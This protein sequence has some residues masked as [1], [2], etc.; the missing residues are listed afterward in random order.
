M[1]PGRRRTELDATLRAAYGEGLLS[2]GTFVD[3]VGEL[4]T[5]GPVH[6]DRLIG[7]LTLRGRRPRFALAGRPAR[8]ARWVMAA[9][10]DGCAPL[11]A[12]DWSGATEM[13]MIGRA[14][15]CDV[16]LHDT[17]ISRQHARLR[18]RDGV[19]V[20]QDLGS[21]NGTRLNGRPVGRGQLRPGDLIAFADRAFR[22]D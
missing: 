21:K 12:L 15:E 22:I 2:H 7:D 1:R 11:L 5:P 10:R 16:C 14:D 8:F 6:T 9:R 4:L 17:T 13:L 19:W 20:V 18:F 3:R